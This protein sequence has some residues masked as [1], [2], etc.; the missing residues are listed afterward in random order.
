[1]A[2]STVTLGGWLGFAGVVGLGVWL[3]A[4]RKRWAGDVYALSASRR[5]GPVVAAVIGALLIVAAVWALVSE[6]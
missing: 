2:L 3:V 4:G 5:V 1:M 6:L